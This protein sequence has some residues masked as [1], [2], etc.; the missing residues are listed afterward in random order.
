[1]SNIIRFPVERTRPSEL[2]EGEDDYLL[3]AIMRQAYEVKHYKPAEQIKMD[4][5]E[6]VE[7]ED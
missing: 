5:I 1:M 3:R 2:L 6:V 4:G 7:Y